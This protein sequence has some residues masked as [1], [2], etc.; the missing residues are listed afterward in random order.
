MTEVEAAAWHGRIAHY[1]PELAAFGADSCRGPSYHS[2]EERADSLL[3][4]GYHVAPSAL[5]LASR[6]TITLIEVR[7]DGSPWVAPGGMLLRMSDGTTY[8]VWDGTFFELRR[9]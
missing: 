3:G 2:R 4:V 1:A 5:G 6:A 9:R 8:T 7:C